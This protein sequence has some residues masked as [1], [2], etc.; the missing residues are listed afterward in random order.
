MVHHKFS[1]DSAGWVGF[2]MTLAGCAAGI[3]AGQVLDISVLGL[4]RQKKSMVILMY[5]WPL[6]CARHAV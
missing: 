4:A 3:V 1:Q 6:P 2:G 5:K